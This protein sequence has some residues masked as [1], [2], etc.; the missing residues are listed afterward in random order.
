M[1]YLNGKDVLI[2]KIVQKF[3]SKNYIGIDIPRVDGTLLAFFNRKVI[4][5][6]S[7]S[8]VSMSMMQKV[9]LADFI[10]H[11]G[12]FDFKIIKTAYT[13]IDLILFLMGEETAKREQNK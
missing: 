4:D 13:S 10:I 9:Q 7:L 3:K 8:D 12:D 5:D 11:V 6:M 2:Q 1:Y